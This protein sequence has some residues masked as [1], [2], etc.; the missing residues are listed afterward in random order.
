ME[1]LLSARHVTRILSFTLTDHLPLFN[2]EKAELGS[3][4]ICSGTHDSKHGV[5]FQ[6]RFV[7]V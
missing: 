1:S 2:R 4:V 3:S 7:R 6:T 5:G